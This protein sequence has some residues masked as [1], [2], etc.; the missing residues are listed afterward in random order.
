MTDTRKDALTALR[1]KVQAEKVGQWFNW[2]SGI[3]GHGADAKLAYKGSL[4]AAKAL[5]DA[6]LPGWTRDVDAT[7][8]ECGIDVTLWRPMPCG[9]DGHFRATHEC[10]A[11]AW[12][13]VILSVLIAEAAT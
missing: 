4:D 13:L 9:Q 3:K 2:D 1:D 6:V 11:R 8:P 5:H 10:E 7:A 12:L